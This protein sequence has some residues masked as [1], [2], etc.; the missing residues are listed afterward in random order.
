MRVSFG[1]KPWSFPQ[2]VYIVATYDESGVPDAM[3]AA[4]GGI[5]GFREISLCLGA[6]H[7]SVANLRRSGA[8]TVSM[9]TEG[10]V[11]AC[12]YVGVVSANDVP[13]KF[14]RAGFTAVRSEVVDAPLIEELP[15]CL[16]CR[17]VSYD[18]AS[19]ILRGE[20]VN[21]SADESVLTDGRIDVAKVR[22]VVFNPVDMAYMA[23]GRR[24]GSAFSDGKVL[25]G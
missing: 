1:A 12:D 14:A 15:M 18:E 10:C 2:P 5:S 9:G 20:I 22:P 4:W 13:D 19:G 24:V 16:E 23:V 11:T 3:N 7:K 25:K 6:S 8:F 21:V 17:V